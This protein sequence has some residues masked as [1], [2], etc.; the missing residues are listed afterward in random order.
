MLCLFFA[1]LKAGTFTLD[2]KDVDTLRSGIHAFAGSKVEYE[3]VERAAEHFAVPHDYA[4]ADKI[5]VLMRTQTL[6]ATV[7]IT[8]LEN[9]D[10]F[11]VNR[12]CYRELRL[13]CVDVPEIMPLSLT[14]TKASPRPPPGLRLP[15]AGFG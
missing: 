10:V 8:N 14:H 13:L 15:P 12:G 6:G 5:A 11:T 9:D 1:G 2:L 3:A 4:T 7:I